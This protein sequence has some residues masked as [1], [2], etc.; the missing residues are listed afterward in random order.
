MKKLWTLATL[1]AFALAATTFAQGPG[2]GICD[3]TGKGYGYRFQAG[4]DQGKG[5]GQRIR[6]RKRDGTCGGTQNRTRQRQGNG[7]G[8]R[9]GGR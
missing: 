9:L 4:N 6:E 1:I 3:G 2:S 7:G 5:N 8:K